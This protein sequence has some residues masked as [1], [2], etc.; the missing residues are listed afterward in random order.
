MQKRL[1]GLVFCLLVLAGCAAAPSDTAAEATAASPTAETRQDAAYRDVLDRCVSYEGGTAG[2]SLKT[3]QAAAGL[4]EFL[5]ADTDEALS[6]ESAAAWRAALSDTQ[7]AALDENWPGIYLCAV[8]LCD[9]PAAQAGLLADAGVETDFSA[10]DL[11]GV[12]E[13]LTA[14]NAALSPEA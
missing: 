13:R 8:S 4:V 1:M 10:M 2:A 6:G 5:A 9:D 12:P 3:A 11:S 7:S 14:L